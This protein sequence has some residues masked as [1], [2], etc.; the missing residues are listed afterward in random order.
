MVDENDFDIDELRM[1]GD[2]NQD[3]A[4]FESIFDD[5]LAAEETKAM[6]MRQHKTA[7]LFA[8]SSGFAPLNSLP[9]QAMNQGSTDGTMECKDE[10]LDDMLTE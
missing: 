10:S 9:K 7:Q 4:A 8:A 1:L 6:Q 2:E 5:D 3:P